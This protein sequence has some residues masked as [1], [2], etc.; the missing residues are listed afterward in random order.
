MPRRLELICAFKDWEECALS[1][2]QVFGR[3]QITFRFFS[4]T[5]LEQMSWVICWKSP[6]LMVSKCLKLASVS[7]EQGGGVELLA[8][9]PLSSLP[10]DTLS[11]SRLWAAAA[12][13][14]LWSLAPYFPASQ[15]SSWTVF[16]AQ[17]LC[18]CWTIKSLVLF[19]SLSACGSN[20]CIQVMN[21]RSRCSAG[22]VSVK[23]APEIAFCRSQRLAQKSVSF[24]SHSGQL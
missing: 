3:L 21:T 18:Y 22:A 11:L 10:I 9:E 4:F 16:L 13:Y 19:L 12:D 23:W 17:T 14:F 24:L 6:L 8:R 20:R 7:Q 15:S 1:D 5:L 2:S